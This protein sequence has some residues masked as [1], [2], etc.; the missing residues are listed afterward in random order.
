MTFIA[1][2]AIC[3]GEV[4]WDVFP[5]KKV[6]GGAPL[7]VALRLQSF[8][9]DTSIISAIGQDKLGKNLISFISEHGLQ[10][11]LIQYS[12]QYPTGTVEVFLDTEGS[13]SYKIKKPVAWDYIL[14]N[15]KNSKA[16]SEAEVLIFGS[17]AC[18][19]I[20]SRDTLMELLS[21]ANFT[22]F[23]VNLRPPDYTIAFVLE[24]MNRSDFIKLND[25]ELH[26]IS[27]HLGFENKSMEDQVKSLAKHTQTKNICV[28]KGSKGALLFLDGL[29]YNNT[30]YKVKVKDTV[31]AGDSFLAALVYKLLFKKS[32]PHI[33]LDFA[34]KVG[35]L[36]ASKKGAS[37]D[38]SQKEIEKL[39]EK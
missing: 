18:R 27:T 39:E 34:C 25:E 21:K 5:D 12:E 11:N 8:E 38:V 3:F 10:T 19:N 1:T 6:I 29:F 22:V 28:T 16:V 15:D 31:G 7:N 30:G 26:L 17:L 4:L 13:A 36:V 23:D 32:E 9:I 24:L 33:A 35:A 20:R 2:S 37:C 14:H